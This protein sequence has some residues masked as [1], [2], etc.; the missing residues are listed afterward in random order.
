[1]RQKGCNQQEVQGHAEAGLQEG[2]QDREQVRLE[3]GLHRGL[4][5][6]DGGE[7]YESSGQERL[8]QHCQADVLSSSGSG[9]RIIDISCRVARAKK[10]KR[11]D[12]KPAHLLTCLLN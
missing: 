10:Y 11:Q 7:V 8:Q 6:K 1:M 3:G 9:L 5:T 4:P 12:G 2:H